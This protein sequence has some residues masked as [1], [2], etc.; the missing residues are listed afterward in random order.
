MTIFFFRFKKLAKFWFHSNHSML[1]TDNEP[2]FC[3]A[4]CDI[5]K[6]VGISDR[7]VTT[8]PA[9]RPLTPPSFKWVWRVQK[10]SDLPRGCKHRAK[11]ADLWT[12]LSSCH[13]DER[14]TLSN[15]THKYPSVCELDSPTVRRWFC[16]ASLSHIPLTP[17]RYLPFYDM[18][19]VR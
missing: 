5:T 19:A 15:P 2:V 1:L 18:I 7:L 11:H 9:N 4:F 16:A 8:P 13:S 6:G 3:S 12:P 17:L 10:M 14:Q